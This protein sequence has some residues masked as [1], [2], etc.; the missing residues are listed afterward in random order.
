MEKL[1]DRIKLIQQTS[2]GNVVENEQDIRLASDP[3]YAEILR[4][5]ASKHIL[6]AEPNDAL[7]YL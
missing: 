7:D 4:K 5:R 1:L 6:G 2:R 3:R